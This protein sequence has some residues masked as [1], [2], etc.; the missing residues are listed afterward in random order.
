MLH[1]F[2]AWRN[3]SNKIK[4]GTFTNREGGKKSGAIQ[5]KKKKLQ[6]LPTDGIASINAVVII[7][8]IM[9][10]SFLPVTWCEMPVILLDHTLTLKLFDVNR[11]NTA[12]ALREFKRMGVMCKAKSPLTPCSMRRM[13]KKIRRKWIVWNV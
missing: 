2:R 8:K 10:W 6:Q 4:I 1:V 12:G 5:K 13:V 9:K 3:N 11:S 7:S